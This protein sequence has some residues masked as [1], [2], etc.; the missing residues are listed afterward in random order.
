[1]YRDWDGFVDMKMIK[2][3]FWVFFAGQLVSVSS[4]LAE[5]QGNSFKA[6]ELQSIRNVSQSILKVRGQKRLE[7]LEETQSLRDEMG[8]VREALQQ[9]VAQGYPA[10]VVNK[11]AYSVDDAYLQEP[12]DSSVQRLLKW[13]RSLNESKPAGEGMSDRTVK[14]KSMQAEKIN[15]IRTILEKRKRKIDEDMPA[16]WQ[17][18]SAA[19][20]RL[21]RIRGAITSIEI[22][23][24]EAS[25]VSGFARTEKLQ[26]LLERLENRKSSDLVEPASVPD[27]TI[28]S[29]TKHFRK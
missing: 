27:P 29:I 3:L 16:F 6:G 5:E 1:L 9:A 13:W 23:V 26:A 19:G 8:L 25:K 10:V 7:V 20:E 17:P 11:E 15:K 22:E 4:V 18:S 28:T 21:A 14:F 2:A 12:T 24:N